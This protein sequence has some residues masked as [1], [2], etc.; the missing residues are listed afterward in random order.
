M[1]NIRNLN[2]VFHNSTSHLS[3]GN[4]LR[5]DAYSVTA[6]FE[7]T[8][9]G[10]STV[11]FECKASDDD[12]FYPIVG[13]NLKDL[14]IKTETNE[15]G[16]VYQVSLEGLTAFRVRVKDY[17][18]GDIS[19]KGTVVYWYGYRFNSKRTSQKGYGD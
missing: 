16:V 12:V 15:K 19:V 11:V 7:I 18:S 17:S 6:T 3:D 10:E 9:S 4:V 2:W 13:I 14:S 5:V 8:G 1:G